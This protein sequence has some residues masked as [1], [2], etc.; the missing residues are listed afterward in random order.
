MTVSASSTRAGRVGAHSGGAP[1][2]WRARAVLAVLGVLLAFVLVEAVLRVLGPR[3]P[4]VH[5][6]TS[7]ASFQTYHPVY[8]FFH[9]PGASGWIQTPEF[10]SWVEISGQ[11]LRDRVFAIPKPAGVYRI[12]MLGDSFVEGAQVPPEATVAKR[13]EDELRARSGRVVDVVNAGNAGFGTA[14]ELLFLEHDGAGFQPDLVVLVFFVD[15]DLPDNGYAVSLERQ[16]DTSRRPFFVPD[17]HGGLRLRPFAAPEAHGMS[18]LKTGLR[19]L[20]VLFN[21]VENVM[22]W[23]EARDQE[24]QQIGKNRPSY[25]VQPPPEWEEAWLVTEGLLGRARESALAMGANFLLVVAPS[26]YQ[27]DE[28]AWRWLVAGTQ[29]RG[30]RYDRE[31]PNRR[32]DGIAARTGVAHFDLLPGVRAAAASGGRL[33]FPEDGHWT[34]EGHAVGARLLADYLVSAGMV[35]TD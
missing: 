13:L 9:R 28:Q 3:V 30:R 12:L 7:I 5:S 18:D 14:Q 2:G 20:S 4:V 11:G 25:Q 35:P 34:V 17:G 32:I 19:Q 29:D 33:Y 26:N 21:I 8:G 6:L 31:T 1:V 22:L 27:V 16:L 24:N 10:T 23:Q 15:N